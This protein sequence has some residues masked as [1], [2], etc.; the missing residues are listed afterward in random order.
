MIKKKLITNH[1]SRKEPF[2]EQSKSVHK[3]K[4]KISIG[5]YY[6]LGGKSRQ[7]FFL[8]SQQLL[9]PS[10]YQRKQGL[11]HNIAMATHNISVNLIRMYKKGND[12]VSQKNYKHII[13]FQESFSILTT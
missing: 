11:E 12:L 9:G 7:K 4:S 2:L 1:Y 10:L 6:L 13:V 8:Q 5:N 3:L